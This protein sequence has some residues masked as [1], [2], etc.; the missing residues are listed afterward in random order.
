M[1]LVLVHDPLVP[2]GTL[3]RF[4]REHR[5]P[6]R[7]LRL[8]AG[9]AVPGDPRE[10]EA[11][12]SLG[13]GMRVLDEGR[14]PFL[15]L[16]TALLSRAVARGVPVLGIGLGAQ[17]LARALGGT[18]LRAPVPEF[19]WGTATLTRAGRRDPLFD[20]L[21][22]PLSVFL[23]HEDTFTLPPG[24]ELLA[25]ADACE[26]QAFRY[27]NSWGLQFHPE[28]DSRIIAALASGEEGCVDVV[29]LRHRALPGFRRRAA[30]LFSNFF[31]L[32][33]GS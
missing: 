17:L 1:I 19:G 20:G 25:T 31:A 4:L 9:E 21:N 16:E 27:G 28:V 5:R 14:H 7:A 22:S 10:A 32:P 24:A 6:Y 33:G 3:G 8:Y 13:G 12:V 2:P 26:N 18:V 23:W 29:R 15:A 30:L 11:I